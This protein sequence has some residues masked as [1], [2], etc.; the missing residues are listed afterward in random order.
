LKHDAQFLAHL[1]SVPATRHVAIRHLITATI[2]S[3]V[4]FGTFHNRALLPPAVLTLWENLRALHGDKKYT[5]G[6]ARLIPA[7]IPR[8]SLTVDQNSSLAM[9]ATLSFPT[10]E[11]TQLRDDIPAL[12]RNPAASGK[13]ESV[14]RPRPQQ[15]RVR[16][17]RGKIP[18]KRAT[19]GTDMGWG[20]TG[21]QN[22]RSPLPVVL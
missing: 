1:C 20:E 11:R 17:S 18:T 21:L 9:A 7:Q 19:R 13:A 16:R 6:R 14:A 15:L 2:L 22:A 10:P 4:D 3:A 5:E 12:R 8:V